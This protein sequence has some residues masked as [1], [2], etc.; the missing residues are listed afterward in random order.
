MKA[1]HVPTVQACQFDEVGEDGGKRTLAEEGAGRDDGEADP[2][3]PDD[4]TEEG[5]DF[6]AEKGREGDDEED[7]DGDEPAAR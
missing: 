6:V 5:D 2:K 4:T 3:A 7:A 1:Y